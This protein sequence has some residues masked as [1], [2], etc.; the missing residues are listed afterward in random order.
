MFNL[1]RLERSLRVFKFEGLDGKEITIS[2]HYPT[3]HEIAAALSVTGADLD[4]AI[5]LSTN[6]E[7]DKENH[8]LEA[9]DLTARLGGAIVEL[10][11]LCIDS[12]SV[13]PVKKIKTPHGLKRISEEAEDKLQPVLSFIGQQLYSG[14]EVTKEEGEV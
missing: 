5:K 3:P 11:C 2:A 4:R 8:A 9:L 14:S 7:G 1:E 6:P 13:M 10:A 12:C